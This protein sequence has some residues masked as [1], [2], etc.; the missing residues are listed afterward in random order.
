MRR[1]G[2][3]QAGEGNARRVKKDER[4]CLYDGDNGPIFFNRPEV[5]MA[6]A[7]LRGASASCQLVSVRGSAHSSI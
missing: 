2:H 4:E 6:V 7:P 5:G 3:R 1:I